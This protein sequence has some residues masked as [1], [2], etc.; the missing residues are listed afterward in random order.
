MVATKAFSVGID[1]S[2]VGLIIHYNIP[3]TMEDYMQSAGRAGRNGE[4]AYDIVLV[5]NKSV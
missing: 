1:K 3:E 5:D 4:N 2:N